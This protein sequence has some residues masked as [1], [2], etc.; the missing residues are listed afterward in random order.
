M[1]DAATDF[2]PLLFTT[3]SDDD[4]AANDNADLFGP[5]VLRAGRRLRI[6]ERLTQIGMDITEALHDRVIADGVAATVDTVT[7]GE[8]AVSA[9]SP[10]SR[11][12][13]F[14]PTEAFAKISRTVRLTL[15]LETKADEALRALQSG[16]FL[17][18]ETR[19]AERKHRE[20]TGSIER[21]QAAHRI[22]NDRVST[23]IDRE[24]LTES[25][26]CDLMEALLERLGED[27]AYLD[28]EDR[29]L[30]ETV[31]RL[32]GDL[33]LSPDMS[34]W[35]GDDWIAHD[36][37]PRRPHWSVFNTPGRTRLYPNGGDP[38]NPTPLE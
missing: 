38:D 24:A 19:K 7:N 12:P 18:G 17:A 13:R 8:N 11:S 26:Y 37:P 16:Q 4:V 30:R 1:P 34:R 33:G 36:G 29:P 9:K 2:V 3:S 22:V 28:I 31:E 27:E 21:S 10:A 20:K 15:N 14:D 5:A 32:C 25:D 35:V 23:A 6:L